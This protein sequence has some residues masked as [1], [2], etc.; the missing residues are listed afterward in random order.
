MVRKDRMIYSKKDASNQ[1][2]G[3]LKRSEEVEASIYYR[4]V[5][6]KR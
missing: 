4:R 3:T 1:S 5:N 2:T 6:R